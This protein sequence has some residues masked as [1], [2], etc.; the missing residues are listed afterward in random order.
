[1]ERSNAKATQVTKIPQC[2]ALSHLSLC[3]IK[4]SYAIEDICQTLRVNSVKHVSC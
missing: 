1:M 3:Y 4:M 2:S